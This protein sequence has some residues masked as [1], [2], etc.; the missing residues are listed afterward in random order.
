[1]AADTADLRNKTRRLKNLAIMRAIDVMEHPED[2]DKETYKE[3][4]LTTLKNSVPRT[5]EITGEEGE[6]IK[7]IFDPVFNESTRETEGDSSITSPV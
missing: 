7:I 3:T 4:Y 6:A 1:M 2:Y 5:Q